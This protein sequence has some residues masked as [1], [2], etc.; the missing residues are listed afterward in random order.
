MKGARNF[1]KDRFEN[2]R[3]QTNNNNDYNMSNNNNNFTENKYN[4]NNQFYKPAYETERIELEEF[5][6]NFNTKLI[7]KDNIH[8]F[9][10]YM[11]ELVSLNYIYILIFYK[12]LL[13]NIM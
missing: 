5:I 13:K 9:K 10:K 4:D 6:R 8:G 12:Y 7:E 3:N 1:T 2:N 11:I